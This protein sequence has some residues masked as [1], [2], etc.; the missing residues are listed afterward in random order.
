MRQKLSAAFFVLS[1]AVVARGEWQV[2]SSSSESS[3]DRSVEHR[4]V[5]MRNETGAEATLDLAVFSPKSH[6]LRVFDE[7][8][9][10]RADL[11]A[12]MERERCIAGTNGGYFDPG[13]A[14][15]GLLVIDGKAVAPFRKA[16]LLSAV[17]TAG[18]GRVQLL[19]S[20]EY[21]TKRNLGTALQC[22]PFLV[23]HGE[24]VAGLNDSRGARRTFVA[25]D[26]ERAAIGFCS[27]AT[28][29]ELGQMLATSGVIGAGKIQR[30]MNLDGGS[31]SAFWFDGGTRP[32]SIPAYKTVRNFLGVGPK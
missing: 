19:R 8:V 15:V 2:A 24:A 5:V 22:G 3:T 28:L 31:S 25:V 4:H 12:V 13:Y 27:G 21:S 18:K 14:P 32:L 9:E 20:P 26:G 10:P 1:F 7:S 11:A 23:D 30:A 29:A 16:H 6:S 17:L